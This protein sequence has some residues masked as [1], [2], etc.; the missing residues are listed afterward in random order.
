VDA[1]REVGGELGTGQLLY[2]TVNPEA[3]RRGG[4]QDEG[5][6]TGRGDVNLSAGEERP[7][8]NGKSAGDLGVG[9]RPRGAGGFLQQVAIRR[10]GAVGF[11]DLPTPG[12][13]RVGDGLGAG[14]AEL[15]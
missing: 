6:R 15:A 9:G 8:P 4:G 14:T 7:R 1:G 3:G 13:G 2:L 12:G 10:G 11:V 5:D